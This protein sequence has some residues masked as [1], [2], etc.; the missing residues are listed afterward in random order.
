MH[1]ASKTRVTC[2]GGLTRPS[3]D[4]GRDVE[5]GPALPR[6]I[7]IELAFEYLRVLYSKSLR[8]A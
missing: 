6:N 4:V 1:N 2:G 8:R 7:L 3:W 5:I